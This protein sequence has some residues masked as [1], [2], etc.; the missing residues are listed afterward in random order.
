[1][2][3]AH[4]REQWRQAAMRVEDLHPGDHVYGYGVAGTEAYREY[5]TVLR[6]NP[7]TVTVRSEINGQ[8]FRVPH[9]WIEGLTPEDELSKEGVVATDLTYEVVE[10]NRG[11]SDHMV[12]V[13]AKSGGELVGFLQAYYHY[14]YDNHRTNEYLSVGT[15]RIWQVWVSE[16][17]RRQ[18]IAEGLLMA[19]HEKFPDYIIVHGGYSSAE[20][21]AFGTAMIRQY[22]VW[23][24]IHPR[25]GMTAAMQTFILY[26]GTNEAALKAIRSDG[27]FRPMNPERVN[28]E[29]EERY[30]LPYDSVW[31]HKY[32][33]FSHGRISD[34]LIYFSTKYDDARFYASFGSEVIAD[35]LEAVV[36]ILMWD[37]LVD[38]N[39]DYRPGAAAKKKAWKEAEA[40][41]HYQPVV[42]TVEVPLDR[43]YP[44]EGTTTVPAPLPASWIKRVD[45]V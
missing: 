6:V 42:L 23:N 40:R 37:E 15:W 31:R 13:S 24:K 2:V 26:H 27:E 9:D 12:E 11:F 22:P 4:L 44:P 3:T 32:N 19:L 41:K 1:M 36:H 10:S 17:H 5:V 21:E 43:A 16:D 29:I 30:G 38:E 33:T 8:E 7:K 45:R 35:A 28:H 20:G 39:G 34:P 14:G 18:G 25:T